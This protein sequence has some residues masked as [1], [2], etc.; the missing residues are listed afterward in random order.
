MPVKSDKVQYNI[1]AINKI[2]KVLIEKQQTI[3]VA[4]SVTSGHLQA[5][6]SLAKEAMEFFQGGMTAYNLGQKSRHF[7]VDPIHAFRY[8]CVSERVAADMA[9][10]VAKIFSS[11]WGIGITGYASPEPENDIKE[12]FAFYSFCYK[13]A[14]MK[15]GKIAVE[16]GQ[17]LKVQISYANYIYQSFLDLLTGK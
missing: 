7:R 15:T 13:G 4:E 17:Q 5:G 14:E 6:F 8:N 3:A 10:G 16:K 2:K 9:K 12:L 11:D 1:T